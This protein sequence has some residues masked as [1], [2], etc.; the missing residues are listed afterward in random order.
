MWQDVCTAAGDHS[1][2]RQADSDRHKV[3][4]ECPH[5]RAELGCE[6]DDQDV[7]GFFFTAILFT[8]H[9]WTALIAIATY[10]LLVGLNVML[11]RVEHHLTCRNTRCPDSRPCWTGTRGRAGF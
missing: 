9:L 6:A 5:R 4:R 11:F 8:Q 10:V 1:R 2:G 3:L 7:A